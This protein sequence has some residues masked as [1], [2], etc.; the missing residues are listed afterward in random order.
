MTNVHGCLQEASRRGGRKHICQPHSGT[1]LLFLLASTYAQRLTPSCKLGCA[2]F[3][4]TEDF[5]V[6]PN[7]R[8]SPHTLSL[9]AVVK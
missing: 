1:M 7:S 2:Q 4:A 5:G 3:S 8:V 9:W 6:Y